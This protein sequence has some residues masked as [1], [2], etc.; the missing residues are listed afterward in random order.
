MYFECTSACQKTCENY[1]TFQESDCELMPLYTCRCPEGQVMKLG[2]CVDP[3]ICETCDALGHIVGDVWKVGPCEQCECMSDLSTRCTIMECPE[4][5]ICNEKQTLK[6]RDQAPDTCCAIYDCVEEVAEVICP[7]A[8][9][10]NCSEGQ[11]NVVS[12]E[13]GCPVYKCECKM[14]LC[15][16]VTQPQVEEG[17]VT[18]IEQEGCCPHYRVDCYPE[19]CSLPPIC[20]P[21]FKVSTFEGKC[22]LKSLYLKEN[23]QKLNLR[24][25]HHGKMV[26]AENVVARPTT[27]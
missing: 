2:Q 23:R 6:K 25:D 1:K 21:G 18:S 24:A 22:C 4:P 15:P 14:E 20:G 9:L 13:N 8:K 7:E 11:A 17:E 26:F 19:K 3:I 27:E 10:Q 16:P 5:P 12:H